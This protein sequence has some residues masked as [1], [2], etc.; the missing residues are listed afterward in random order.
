MNADGSERGVLL[1]DSVKSA[2]APSWSPRGDRIAFAFGRFFPAVLGSSSAA[3]AVMQADGSGVTLL[4]GSEDNAGFPSWAPDGRQL[5]YRVTNAGRSGLRI[6]NV[7]TRVV[8]T[9][10]EPGDDNSPAWSPRGDRIAFTA[11]RGAADYDIFTVRVDG[12]DVR[13]LTTVAG[14]DS[15]PAWSPDGEWIVFTTARHGFK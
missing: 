2:L 13:R 3:I 10:T 14:N 6:V 5:V 1:R 15:H 4:T 9:L 7:G 12:T 8:R 11:K